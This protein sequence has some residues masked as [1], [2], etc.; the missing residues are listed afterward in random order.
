M[1][2]FFWHNKDVRKSHWLAWDKLCGRKE[3][4]GLGFWKMGAFNLAILAK[5]LWRI[6]SNTDIVLSRLLKHK[7][8]PTSDVLTATPSQG[9]SFTWK[10]IPNSLYLDETADALIE[11]GGETWN[12]GLSCSVFWFENAELILN[13]PLELG[14][15][16]V[17]RWHYERNV[18]SPEVRLFAWEVCGDAL[19]VLSPCRSAEC[20]KASLRVRHLGA[21]G[22]EATRQAIHS[23]SESD[24]VG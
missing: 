10:S 23:I 7:Y 19:L 5:Q 11:E 18:V 17:F 6:V 1:A 2:D 16:D 4:G 15:S 13:I 12:E 3:A 14:T 24:V 9:Y 8:F 22:L 20:Y 21:E